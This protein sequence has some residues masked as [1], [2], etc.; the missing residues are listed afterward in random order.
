MD[1]ATQLGEGKIFKLLLKFSIPAITGMLVNALYN[2]VD[3]AFVGQKVDTVGIAAVTASYPLMTVMMA[4]GMLV[5]IGA[6]ALISIRLGEGRREEAEKVVGSAFVLLIAI[7]LLITVLGFIFLNPLLRISGADDEVLPYAR[8][9]MQIILAGG[10]FMGIGFGMNNFIRA[11]GNPITSMLTMLIGAFANIIL[12]PIFIF[13]FGWGIRGSALATVISQAI[14]AAWVLSYFVS[15]RSSLKLHLKNLKVSMA[16]AGGIFA[17]G[18]APF[19]MQLAASVLTAILNNSLLVYGGVDAMSAMGAI[20]SISMLILM[21]IFGINQGAQPIIG[22]N[23]GAGKYDR[24]KKTLKLAIIAATIVV[25][26]GFLVTRFFPEQIM[27]M[28][29]NRNEE[30]IRLGVKSMTIYLLMLPVTGFQIVGA[31]YFQAVGKPGKAAL[32]SLSRQVLI[33]IPALFVLPRFFGLN[34]VLAAGPV[35]DILSSLITGT[36]LYLELKHLGRKHEE[37]LSSADMRLEPGK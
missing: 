33:L 4:F 22:Y 36:F 32:L 11:E 34:G 19:A 27:R 10:V 5:G 29:N 31:N 28:F 25:F 16:I 12:N 26:I 6:T 2:V 20:T 14:S 15:G 24:V 23:Y 17:I 21:P 9:F 18:S 8:Q 30:F 13:V 1:R 35:S 37:S 3:R 7:S